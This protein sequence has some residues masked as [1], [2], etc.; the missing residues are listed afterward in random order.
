MSTEAS[1][2]AEAAERAPGTLLDAAALRTAPQDARA[3]SIDLRPLKTL[4]DRIEENYHPE[5]IWL[6]GSRAR[7]DARPTSDWDV[8]VVVPDGTD[9]RA[10]DPRAAWRLQRGSGVYADVIPCRAS[11]FIED[12]AT[13]NTLAYIVANEGVLI[14]ER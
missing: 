11:E 13:V 10:L 4:L 1:Q 14:Y 8:F 7:G 3:R 2:A 5:Q 12:R 9:E 6:F